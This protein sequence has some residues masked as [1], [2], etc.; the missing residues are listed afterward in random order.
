[1]TCKALLELALTLFSDPSSGT[2]LITESESTGERPENR[3]VSKLL[4]SLLAGWME[5]HFRL[6]VTIHRH[7][8]DLLNSS[9]ST[10]Y[11]PSQLRAQLIT[12]RQPAMCVSSFPPA[13]LKGLP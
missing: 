9:P 11:Q 1:M 8:S 12:F 10:R 7:N 13:W 4:R 2:V 6:I 3:A 5:K